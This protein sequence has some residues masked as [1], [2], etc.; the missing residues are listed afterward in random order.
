MKKNLLGVVL[1]ALMAVSG[2]A[3]A[4]GIV[5]GKREWRQLTGTTGFS[6]NEI[7][8]ACDPTTGRC[9][10]NFSDED[11]ACIDIAPCFG[12]WTWAGNEDLQVLFEAL[13]RPD[14]IQFPTPTSD[15]VA[16]QDDDIEAAVGE[17]FWR[18][19]SVIAVD[20]VWGWSRSGPATGACRY[21]PFLE[22]GSEYENTVINDRAMLSGCWS[23]DFR[24]IAT[25]IWFY[26][27]VPEPGSLALLGLGLAGLGFSR[28]R[29]AT[30]A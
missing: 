23:P 13:I 3:D 11:G 6:W 24:S 8:E 5:V 17:L 29:G 16:E 9:A 18:T 4:S 1:V 7:A 2:G 19:G 30:T 10:P 21:T 20:I 26:R 25:G 22:S 14:S 27:P 15:Y 28:R 12:G